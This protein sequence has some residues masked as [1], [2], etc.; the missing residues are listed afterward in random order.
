MSTSPVSDHLKATV[1]KALGRVPSGVYILSAA[2][3]GQ[4][5][6]MMVSWVQQAAFDPP[7]V[8]VAFHKERPIRQVV[9]DS[10]RFALTVIGEGD[11]ALMKKYA[12]GVPPGE[13]PFAGVETLRTPG[14]LQV[15]SGALAWIEGQVL[16][17]LDFG[18]DHELV[19]ARINDGGLLREGGPFVHLRGNGF[20]Y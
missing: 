7:A 14:G 9:R 18:G 12:R 16:D 4:S 5:M 10:G 6:A 15:P 1:G 2:H 17:A 20:H 11:S 19:V 3:A 13:D 8:S